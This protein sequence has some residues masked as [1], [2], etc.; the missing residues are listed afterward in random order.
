MFCAFIVKAQHNLVLNGS[1]EINTEIQCLHSMNLTTWNS[2]VANSTSYGTGQT[3]LLR[4]SCISCSYFPNYYWG[5]GAQ[6]G[7]WFTYVHSLDYFNLLD[8][9]TTW[10]QSK[11]SLVLDSALSDT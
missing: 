5:G 11:I 9:S 1:F 10:S 6:S 8:S 7:H 4:D 2:T 3:A